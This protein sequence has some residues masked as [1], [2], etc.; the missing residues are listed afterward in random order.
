MYE[1]TI[2]KPNKSCLKKVLIKGTMD[3]MNLIKVDYMHL[4]NYL[5]EIPLYN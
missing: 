2:M 3:G 5:N 1:N 4:C